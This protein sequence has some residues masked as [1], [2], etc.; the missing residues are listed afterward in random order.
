MLNAVPSDWAT[1]AARA[2]NSR[3]SSTEITPNLRPRNRRLISVDDD[4][5]NLPSA[6]QSPKPVQEST[7]SAFFLNSRAASP[8]PSTRP[9]RSISTNRGVSKASRDDRVQGRNM[10]PRSTSNLF[11]G[12]LW[13]NSWSSFQ[14]IASTLLGSDLPPQAKGAFGSQR[15]RKL[16][17][18]QN[19]RLSISTRPGDWGPSGNDDKHVASGSKEDRL[20][21]VQAKKRE[22]LLEINEHAAID[23][24]G[25]YKRRTSDELIDGSP[26]PQEQA[27]DTLVYLHHVQ[28]TDTLMGVTIKYHCSAAVFR[29]TNRLWPNDS[30]QIRQVVY[31][32]VNACGVKGRKVSSPSS[33]AIDLLNNTSSS[34]FTDSTVLLQ[35]SHPE[36]QLPTS[37]PSNSPA[38]S[39]PSSPSPYTHDSWVSLPAFPTSTQIVRLPLQTLGYFPPSRR[40]STRSSAYS[41]ATTPPH[42]FDLT[43]SPKIPPILSSASSPDRPLHSFR[44]RTDSSTRTVSQVRAQSAAPQDILARHFSGPGGVGSLRSSHPAP[45]PAEDPL[46]KFVERN[47]PSIAPSAF[48][49]LEDDPERTPRLSSRT[50]GGLR[51][52]MH[53]RQG[54]SRGGTRRSFESVSS[55]TST[56]QNVGGA[57]E[58]WVR[59]VAGG[60]GVKGLGGT[61]TPEEISRSAE[62]DLIELVEGWELDAA[63]SGDGRA[64]GEQGSLGRDGAETL[65]ERFPPKGKVFEEEGRRR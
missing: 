45:G 22:A 43:R 28:P 2:M 41:G 63:Y 48:V 14:G 54:S 60:V 40:K 21:Q 51:S 53:S 56:A 4:L 8:I 32:P 64:R 15:R 27:R 46:N 61:S 30:I 7:T 55:S 39:N 20:A 17:E 23:R 31:L 18:S 36:H 47:F 44:P 59:R 62:G 5:E 49:E 33:S 13:E 9:S 24:S 52:G 26:R 16:P 12:S 58:G 11:G 34:G 10:A 3:P 38:P 19:G 42:S 37:Q 65:A 1:P 57:I 50:L 35:S 6:P 25:N 29:K